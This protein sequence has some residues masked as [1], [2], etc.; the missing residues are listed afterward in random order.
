MNRVSEY[1]TKMNRKRSAWNRNESPF[2]NEI[3]FIFLL[4]IFLSAAGQSQTDH[5]DR[6]RGPLAEA[7]PV[8]MEDYGSGSNFLLDVYQRWI[9]PVKGGNLCPMYPSCSQYSKI[10]FETKPVYEAYAG[11]FDRILRCGHEL[12]LYQE[13]I[14]DERVRWYDPPDRNVHE[15]DFA[16]GNAIT[17]SKYQTASMPASISPP[18][19]GGELFADYLF[20][21]KEY[22]RASTEYMRL[23]FYS[24]DS[25]KQIN[26]LS[27]AGLCYFYG[28]DYNSYISHMEENR[29][30]YKTADTIRALMDLFLGKTY[31]HLKKYQKAISTVEWSNIQSGNRYFDEAQFIIGITYAKMFEWERAC[32][33][34]SHI[35]PLSPRGISVGHIADSLQSGTALPARQ[36]WLAGLLSAAVPGTGYFYSGRPQ[37]GAASFIVNAL[38]AWS[39][40]DAVRQKS[41]GLTAVLGFFGTGWYIGNITG[42]AN[43][44]RDYNM[45]IRNNFVDKIIEKIDIDN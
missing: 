35:S 24:R 16:F 30:R 20:H 9:S 33:H 11:T 23:G 6:M 36:P 40:R 39:I 31:Y 3:L 21:R 1:F 19:S 29:E 37:T 32:K 15:E 22:Y 44:A 25:I 45:N 14:A 8:S 13:I 7:K 27:K 5:P 34:L 17:L 4:L 12:N 43:A 18:D 10:L 26:Y 41:Y 2:V 42:S 28:Q 38:L